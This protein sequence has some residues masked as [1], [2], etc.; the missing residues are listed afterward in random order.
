[1]TRIGI[2]GAGQSGLLLA[3]GLVQAGFEVDVYADRTPEEIFGGRVSSTQCLFHPARQHERAVGINFWEDEVPPIKGFRY[4]VDVPG[5]PHFH[6]T[7]RL[8]SPAESVDQ[9]VKFA[10]WLAHFASLGGRVVQK[11]IEED[12]IGELASAHDFVV[13]STGKGVLGRMF[14]RNDD[15][16]EFTEPQ[17]GLGLVYLRGLDPEVFGDDCVN[18]NVIPGMGEFFSMPVLTTTE[19]GPA[20][21]CVFEG[22]PG[23]PL[24]AFRAPELRTSPQA[25]LAAVRKVFEDHMPWLA[26]GIRDDFR[27]TD[28][29]GTLSGAFPPTV[30]KAWAELPG[31]TVAMSLGDAAILNDPITGQGSNTATHHAWCALEMI[32]AH[33]GPCGRDLAQAIFDRHWAYAQHVVRFTN[34]L[35][36]PVPQHVVGLLAAQSPAIGD[37]LADGFANPPQL[38]PWFF[39]P[40]EAASLIARVSSPA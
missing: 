2:V 38:A 23:G 20:W 30:R 31:G 6:F 27:L 21:A 8:S 40:D 18:L 26:A 28:P 16:S 9:R 3:I 10:R 12:D 29:K 34:M 13:V 7:G 15:L 17:R 11:T 14:P 22:V 5:G 4:H 19:D 36:K 24:D 39:E 35:L 33:K 1:M 37:M 32:T 25:F